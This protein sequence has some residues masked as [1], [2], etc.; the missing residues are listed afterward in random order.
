MNKSLSRLAC[1]TAAVCGLLCSAQ[2]LAEPSSIQF[3]LRTTGDTFMMNFGDDLRNK[4]GKSNMSM[5]TYDAV[6]KS[7]EQREQ[8]KKQSMNSGLMVVDIVDP[9]DGDDFGNII[10][11]KEATVIFV[12]RKPEGD[13]LKNYEKAW[14]VGC[15]SEQ[16]GKLQSEMIINHIKKNGFDDRNRNGV[17]DILLFRGPEDHQD[18]IARTKMIKEALDASG[19]KYKFTYDFMCAWSFEKAFSETMNIAE[20]GKLNDIDMVISNNDDMALGAMMAMD[21]YNDFSEEYKKPPIFGID[22]IPSAV[23]AVRDGQ[24]TGTIIQDYSKMADVTIAIAKGETDL[25]KLSKIANTVIK[26]HYIYIP[27]AKVTQVEF[28]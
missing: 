14:Y 6:D 10:S 11:K 7:S 1:S 19:I 13:F 21:D 4:A 3:Y 15:I 28:K 5:I 16:A 18:A 25:K 23:A 2:V 8:I 26:D 27:Y 9:A 22:A 20:K 17:L 12:N 24:M